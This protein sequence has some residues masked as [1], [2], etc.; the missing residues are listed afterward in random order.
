M[1]KNSRTIQIKETASSYKLCTGLVV[2]KRKRNKTP[3]KSVKGLIQK[4][5]RGKGRV[6][7]K[8]KERGSKKKW[9]LRG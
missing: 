3:K 1:E 5:S 2:E 7:E 6:E 8:V 4:V 9:R